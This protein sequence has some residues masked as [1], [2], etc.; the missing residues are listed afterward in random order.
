MTGLTK[1]LATNKYMKSTKQFAS[2]FALA[3]A[4]SL[5]AG[6]SRQS[7]AAASPK[8]TD[9]GI[10]EVSEGVPSQHVLADGRMCT[11]TPT[12]LNDGKVK[13]VIRIRG[14]NAAGDVLSSS[15]VFDAV[16]D[17]ATTYAFDKSNV[18]TV[19]LHVAK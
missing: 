9:F 10:V 3:L 17:Q 12:L 15:L 18:I 14:T 6:C 4:V 19:T 16:A 13:L 8:T 11:L 7:P 5:F 2:L 1:T